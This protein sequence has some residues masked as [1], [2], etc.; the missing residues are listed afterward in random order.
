MSRPYKLPT[1]LTNRLQ[2]AAEDLRGLG[3]ELRDQWD[4]RSERWQESARGEAVRDWLDQIDMAADELETL[5]D[6]L[7]ERPDDEL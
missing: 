6:D 2:A 4:E 5:V 1:S 3:E 7:P